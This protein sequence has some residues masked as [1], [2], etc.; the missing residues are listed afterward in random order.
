MGVSENYGYPQII[1][2][3]RVFH[4]KPSILGYRYCWKRPYIFAGEISSAHLKKK[5]PDLGSQFRRK[6]EG[7]K[8]VEKQFILRSFFMGGVE[9]KEIWMFGVMEKHQIRFD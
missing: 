4:Y 2:V 6:K 8:G 1:H 7:V 3:N 5:H 9:T